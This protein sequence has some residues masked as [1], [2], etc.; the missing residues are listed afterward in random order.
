MQ[1]SFGGQAVVSTVAVQSQP[2]PEGRDRIAKCDG[3]P[4]DPRPPGLGCQASFDQ[5]QSGGERLHRHRCTYLSSLRLFV[6]REKIARN[7]EPIIHGIDQHPRF[8][9]LHSFNQAFNRH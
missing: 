9:G 1:A 6:F 3:L 2:R 7:E 4:L 5:R 8:A